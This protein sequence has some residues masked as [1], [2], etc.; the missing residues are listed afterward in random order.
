MSHFTTSSKIELF[1]RNNISGHLDKWIKMLESGNL[2]DFELGLFDALN[3][4]YDKICEELMTRASEQIKD[5]LISNGKAMGGRKIEMRQ[6]SLRLATGHKI[7]MMSP[8]VKEPGKDWMGSRHLLE[9]HWNTIGGSTPFLSD[10]VGFCSALGPSYDLAHQT[11]SKFGVDISVSSVRDITNRLANRCFDLGEEN[12]VLEK[13]ES[14]AGKR[15]IISIDGGRT[16][17]RKYIESDGDANQLNYETPWCEPKLFVI[18]VLNN[19]GQIDNYRLPIYG[20]RFSEENLFA[21]LERY[22]IILEIDKAAQVQILADGAPWIWNNTKSLLIRLNVKPS[23]IIETLD[24]YHATQYLHSLIDAMPARI[25]KKQRASYLKQFKLWLWTGMVDQIIQI[26]RKIFKRPNQLVK[27]WICYLEKHMG[28]TQYADYEKDKL[29]CGSGIIES[30]IR[31]II[32]LR[33]KNA[34]TFWKKEVVEKLYLLRISLLSKR[35]NLLINN[36][37]S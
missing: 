37:S 15:V 16:R 17:I 4:T 18:D 9:N 6:T 32:N 23:K 3:I 7:N 22:L 25:G 2:Y 24:Y 5:E 26:C 1:I 8:Y 29:M 12:L 35:W 14:L 21:L 27:R 20:C 19:D 33:F 10:K 30:G 28:K 36:L 31:R 11:L 34:S 13:N